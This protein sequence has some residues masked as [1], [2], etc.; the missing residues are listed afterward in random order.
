MHPA[1][2]SEAFIPGASPLLD[3]TGKSTEMMFR[4]GINKPLLAL[5]E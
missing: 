4:D 3:Q 2:C 1:N 5:Q